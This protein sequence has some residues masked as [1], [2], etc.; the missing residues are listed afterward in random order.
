M[1]EEINIKELSQKE[2]FWYM[3]KLL[4]EPIPAEIDLDN[5][6]ANEYARKVDAEIMKN[7][8][9]ENNIK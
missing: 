8:K 9:I 6:I 4:D 7:M 3:W 2:R 5:Y 1:E